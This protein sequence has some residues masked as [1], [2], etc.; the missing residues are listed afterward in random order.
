MTPTTP[1]RSSSRCASWSNKSTCWRSS[2][3]STTRASLSG[4]A[5][6][7]GTGGMSASRRFA[8]IKRPLDRFGSETFQTALAAGREKYHQAKG[9]VCA[10]RRPSHAASRNRSPSDHGRLRLVATIEP[11]GAATLQISRSA[12]HGLRT[13]FV[14]ARPFKLARI[15]NA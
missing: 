13:K 12:G 9:Q 14:G 8:A 5:K 11:R 4:H 10:K 7:W 6:S 15:V 1:P 2:A 3:L